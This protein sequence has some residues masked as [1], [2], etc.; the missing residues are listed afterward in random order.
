MGVKR[1]SDLHGLMS[2]NGHGLHMRPFLNYLVK[3]VGAKLHGTLALGRNMLKTSKPKIYVV[4]KRSSRIFPA[5]F[6]LR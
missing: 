4:G 3:S 1:K 2:V 6:K 5:T